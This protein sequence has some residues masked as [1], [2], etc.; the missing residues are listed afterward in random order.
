MAIAWDGKQWKGDEAAAAVSGAGTPLVA[1]AAST[2]FFNPALKA[3]TTTACTASM[4]Y[5]IP[6]TA[7]NIEVP[8]IKAAGIKMTSKSY[9]TVV[10]TN[11]AKA[12]CKNGTGFTC[13]TDGKTAGTDGTGGDTAGVYVA[14]GLGVYQAIPTAV[15]AF[16]FAWAINIKAAGGNKNTTNDTKKKSA[17]TL[18]VGVAAGLVAAAIA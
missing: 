5:T 3:T 11:G 10:A 16:K 17:T 6:A 18:A 15:N 7:K 12:G 4:T 13:K 8:K 2:T 1:K 14:E 9:A